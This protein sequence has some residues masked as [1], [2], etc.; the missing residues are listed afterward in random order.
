MRFFFYAD[1]LFLSN[2]FFFFRIPLRSDTRSKL[3]LTN[4]SGY[5]MSL[6]M[7]YFLSGAMINDLDTN[8]IKYKVVRLI[9]QI[10][11]YEI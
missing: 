6:L 5:N 8:V 4:G 1:P 3:K 11:F 2:I 10:D 7:E 9:G